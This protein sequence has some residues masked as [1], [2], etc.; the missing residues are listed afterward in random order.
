MLC[1]L[2]AGT[3]KTEVLNAVPVTEKTGE[4]VSGF[5]GTKFRLAARR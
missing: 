4:T 1:N 5:T 2:S 3:V